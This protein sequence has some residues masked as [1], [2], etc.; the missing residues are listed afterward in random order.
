M[1]L[2]APSHFSW[3]WSVI[4]NGSNRWFVVPGISGW[5]WLVSQGGSGWFYVVSGSF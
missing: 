5:F 3:F 1:V 2:G 4:Q